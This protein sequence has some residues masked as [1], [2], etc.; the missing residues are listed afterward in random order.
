MPTLLRGVGVGAGYFSRF[1]YDA[2]RRLPGAEIVAVADLDAGKARAAAAEFGIPRTYTD[3]GAMLAAERPDFVDVITPPETHHALCV[4]AARHDA[5]VICQKP[6][7]P[8]YAEAERLVAEVAATGVRFMVHENWRWQPW[9]REIKRLLDD[10]TLGEP[11]AL[12]FRMR[13]GD[14]HGD[15]AYLARQPYFRD[16]PRLLLYETGVHFVDTFRYLLGEV[17]TVYARLR[18]L[19]PVIAGED[20]GHVVFGFAGGATA[21]YDA[22]RYNEP[23]TDDDP[24]YTFGTLRLDAANGHLRLH[25]DGRITVKLLDQP[26]YPHRYDPPRRGMAGDSCLALQRHFVESVRAGTP[27]ESEGPDY[28]RTLR[29]VEACYTSAASGEAVHINT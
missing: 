11:F 2:W 29:V 10:G 14:G 13:T 22:N 26:A 28:L 8:T 19:N 24:R 4:E 17:E 15:D 7:A 21:V 12:T 1:Q 27:F 18:R 3:V 23:E 25:T 6:L 16:Y 9:Y 20:A 5:H